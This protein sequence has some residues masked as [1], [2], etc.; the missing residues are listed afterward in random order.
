MRFEGGG[1]PPVDVTFEAV[2]PSVRFDM[3]HTCE[4]PE[5]WL[6]WRTLVEARV[7]GWDEPCR[8]WF[9]TSR[10]GTG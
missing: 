10:Y 2:A 9:E 3:A 5:R 6:Y 1:A 7:E 8:G 4:V